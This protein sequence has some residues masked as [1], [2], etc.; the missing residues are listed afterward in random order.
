MKHFKI[1]PVS[2]ITLILIIV[3]GL[4]FTKTK[5]TVGNAEFNAND[6]N[7]YPSNCFIKF[8]NKK[9]LIHEIYKYRNKTLSE[10]WFIASEGFAVQKFEFPFEMNYSNEQKAHK[11]LK[12]TADK[13]FIEFDSQKYKID[14]KRNDTI[15]SK[16]NDKKIIIFIDEY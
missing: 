4:I 2:I 11:F 10:Y 16:I 13:Q 5:L 12:Y 15:I 6:E 9:F 1:K 8:E 3:G 14:E 7:I